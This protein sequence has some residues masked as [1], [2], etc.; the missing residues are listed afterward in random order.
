M[1]VH[2]VIQAPNLAQIYID[3]LQTISDMEPLEIRLFY[4][5]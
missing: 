4:L 3:M 1:I 2:I 5:P